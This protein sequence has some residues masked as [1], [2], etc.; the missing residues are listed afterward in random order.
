MIA[1]RGRAFAWI[2]RL[3]DSIRP[4]GPMFSVLLPSKDRLHLLQH[5]IASV[6]AQHEESVEIIV[7]DNAS[8]DDYASYLGRLSGIVVRH[9]RCDN[10]VSVTANWNRALD[11][12]RG[13]YVIM[14]GDDD[15]LVPHLLQN[16]KIAIE[17]FNKPDVVYMMAYHYAYPGVF[18][19]TPSGYFCTV[20]NSPLFDISKQPF[21]LNRD[22]GQRLA[23]QAFRFR[24]HISFNAQ[25][26]VWKRSFLQRMRQPTGFFQ[27][28]YPDFYASFVTF[29]SDARIVVVPSPQ[30]IIGISKNSFGF[31]FANGRQQE[32]AQAFLTETTPDADLAG[33]DETVL[34]ALRI[35]GSL[36]YRNWMI[37]ALI[38]RQALS[39]ELGLQIDLRRYRR[40]QS[41]ELAFEAGFAKTLSHAEAW[42][43]IDAADPR[44]RPFMKR[45][46]RLFMTFDRMQAI[47]R[48]VVQPSMMALANIHH[49]PTIIS[50]DIGQHQT[51]MD[52]YH[53]LEA[54]PG[55]PML[56]P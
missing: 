49:P 32:G 17:R 5:A 53:W 36:H 9:T 26:Y 38:A 16:L 54:N 21:L 19:H 44:D 28:P 7:A 12:A 2:H 25:H 52:A 15:A 24:H 48:H 41:M 3:Q 8:A 18:S 11:L 37:A 33:G 27:S 31:Y 39:P 46:L 56:L 30:V 29:L 10:P 55:Q 35:S 40:I 6:V 47:P 43:Q 50:H 23:R 14:L 22:T 13:E 42:R 34:Q 51:I 45:M 4:V 20:N 1:S